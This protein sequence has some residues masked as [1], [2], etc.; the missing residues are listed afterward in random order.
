MTLQT[1]YETERLHIRPT[2]RDDASF[3]YELLNTPKWL[4]FIG[5][6]NISSVEKA[7]NYIMEK[8]LPQLEK[9]GFSNNTVIRK[10]DG[11]K[12]GTCGLYD[13]N[14]VDGL[15]IGFAFL[16]QYE[17]QGY[18]FEA[19]DRILEYAREELNIKELSGITTQENL[20][21]QKL[22]KKLGLAF[23]KIIKLTEEDEEIMLFKITF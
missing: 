9:L 23:V 18:A 15:D 14:G 3:I 12:I 1:I 22:L 10:S 20:S 8:M 6:R 2:T 4:Q 11:A 13:R 19:A 21:S 7:E 16:P 17:G 5:D